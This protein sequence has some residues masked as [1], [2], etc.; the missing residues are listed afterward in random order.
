MPPNDHT[1]RTAR[2]LAI[3]LDRAIQQFRSAHP[4]ASAADVS[5]ALHIALAQV[6]SSHRL[7]PAQGL[8]LGLGISALVGTTAFAAKM[9]QDGG[10][11]LVALLIGSFFVVSLAVVFVFARRHG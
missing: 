9:V 2:E 7:S 4:K 10:T 11:G 8:A 6:S 5:A 1:S 3:H